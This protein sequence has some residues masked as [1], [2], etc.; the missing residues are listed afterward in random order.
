MRIFTIIELKVNNF[1]QQFAKV[2]R[3]R[4]SKMVIINKRQFVL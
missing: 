3:T 1:Y 4:D 2:K